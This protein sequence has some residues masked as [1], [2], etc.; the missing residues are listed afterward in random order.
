MG[1][2]SPSWLAELTLRTGPPWLSMGTRA[3]RGRPLPEVGGPERSRL[4]RRR[5]E[6]LLTAHDLV[7]V[8][9]PGAEAAADEAARLVAG[10]AGE[11]LDRNRPRL[12]AAALLV[13][14]DLVVLVRSGGAWRMAAGVVCFP[15]HWSPVEK[16][17]LPVAAIHGPVP[18]Y[19]GELGDRVDR[20]LD[21]L[22]PD[23]PV[24][25][26]NWTVHASPELHAPHPVV[27]PVPVAYQD[28]WLRSE[29]QVLMALPRSASILFTIRTEQVPMTT[30]S[31][32]PPMANRLAAALRSTPPE[33]A[34]YRFGTLDVDGLAAWLERKGAVPTDAAPPGLEVAS[35]RAQSG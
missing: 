12:E 3:V 18:H 30:V 6:L 24:W 2:L 7:S 34:A 17:G 16:L 9:M 22:S 15:S 27:S 19:A 21:R 20:F 28:H 1:T 35:E 13:P 4:R 31:E 23:R 11:M 29:R 14:D 25:R 32:Q 8:A 26:R 5:E 33:L 10:V